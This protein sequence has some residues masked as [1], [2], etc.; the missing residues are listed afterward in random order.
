MKEGEDPL[1]NELNAFDDTL[2]NYDERKSRKEKLLVPSL[3]IF[4]I[5]ASL[6]DGRLVVLDIMEP[7]EYDFS[8]ILLNSEIENG[9]SWPFTEQLS[10]E[11]FLSY[12]VAYDA[13]TVRLKEKAE[14]LNTANIQM[15]NNICGIFY[16]KPNFPGRCNHIC[17]GG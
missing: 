5:E 16:V 8:M 11:D 10:K 13:F 2:Y 7:E 1:D 15:E 6:K 4:P 14:S 9:N 17:N 12:F 3:Q